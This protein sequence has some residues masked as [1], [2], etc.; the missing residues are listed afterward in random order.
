MGLGDLFGDSD[1][2]NAANSNYQNAT[3]VNTST[4]GAM[5]NGQYFGDASGDYGKQQDAAN[6][7]NLAAQG[8]AP[9]AA[10]IQMQNGQNAA[11]AQIQSAAMQHQGGVAP[12]L[13]QRN[14]N[15]AQAGLND[16]II[17]QGAALRATEQATARQQY[18]DAITK[19]RAQS[20]QEA[21]QKQGFDLARLGQIEGNNLGKLNGTLGTV[22]GNAGAAQGGV[23][24]IANIA[25][26]A[27]GIA[28][29]GA[30]AVAP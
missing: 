1:Q 3:D 16:Q 6:M 13:T 27:G 17:G 30:K 24:S 12:G 23:N 2:T 19:M 11:N 9:S 22:N 5:N 25:N 4:L 8:Q 18:S 15:V 7:L 26:A 21:G 14:M 29:G 28:T 20:Q 10:A